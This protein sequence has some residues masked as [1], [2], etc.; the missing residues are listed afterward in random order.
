MVV[1]SSIDDDDETLHAEPK[2]Q[3]LE[4]NNAPDVVSRIPVNKSSIVYIGSL[5]RNKRKMKD[6]SEFDA[7]VCAISSAVFY[8]AMRLKLFTSE[9]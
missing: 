6:D 5:N 4:R 1:F 9:L 2:V 3:L 8:L 7:M